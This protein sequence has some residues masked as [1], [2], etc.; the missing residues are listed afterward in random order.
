MRIPAQRW[1]R[2]R[3]LAAALLVATVTVGDS[4]SATR[5]Q[6]QWWQPRFVATFT[7][8]ATD[9]S[10]NILAVPMESQP[11]G[12]I[13]HQ[14]FDPRL[15]CPVDLG[16]QWSAADVLVTLMVGCEPYGRTDAAALA[17]PD[18]LLV[19]RVIDKGSPG[20]AIAYVH[21]RET[22]TG[23]S[24]LG[25]GY[26]RSDPKLTTLDARPAVETT[27]T[28]TFVSV[29]NAAVAVGGSVLVLRSSATPATNK[30]FFAA[31]IARLTAPRHQ[32]KVA[33]VTAIPAFRCM[34]TS[35][36][37]ALDRQSDG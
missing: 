36:C 30:R 14:P 2:A 24:D 27:L 1:A 22:R 19:E 37:A 32:P 7:I 15:L 20:A 28:T 29:Q 23:C 26:H 5:G 16:S 34:S 10:G 25:H 31:A 21:D 3:V 17:G 8:T 9:N 6:W 18:G 13:N 35:A 12:V 11:C 4:A 33:D